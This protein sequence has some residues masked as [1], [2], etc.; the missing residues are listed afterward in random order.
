[1]NANRNKSESLRVLHLVRAL[2][3][4]GLEKVVVD[5]THGL[6][7][8][9]V[10]NYLG[11]LVE[12]GVWCDDAEVA[13]VWCGDLESRG[14][15]RTFFDL[16]RYVKENNIDV[17]HTHNS[18]PHK[19]GVPVSVFTGV[20]LVHTKHGRNWPE[21]PRWVWFSRQ[22]SRFTKVIVP[23]SHEI[24]KIVV[25]VEKVPQRKVVTI[26][27]GVTVSVLSRHSET[28]PDLRGEG[29]D[30]TIGDKTISALRE[31][32]FVIGSIGRF[33]AEKQYPFL[34]RAFARFLEVSD[35]SPIRLI[36]VG[37]GVERENIEA[38]IERCGVGEYVLLPGVSCDVRGWLDQM[39]VFCLS[40]DQEGTSITLLEAGAAGVPSVVTDVGG[41]AEI[42]KDGVTGI[43]VPFGD[44]E[45]MSDAFLK[46]AGLEAGGSSS[47]REQMGMAAHERIKAEYSLDVMIDKYVEVYKRS[48]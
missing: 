43:V 33:S 16:C 38:E 11:C 34:V 36:L 30:K 19:Y 22:L 46:L 5:L 20:P 44:E 14:P 18:H 9:G 26:L 7:E 32:E 10:T 42:V 2:N 4:G 13:G 28:T 48:Y 41:N 37:D 29:F 35:R 23:V 25:D 8:R 12:K 45:K 24:E 47:V 39:D 40:S 21:N 15:V 6:S 31:G 27:N 1:M 17:I 3:V